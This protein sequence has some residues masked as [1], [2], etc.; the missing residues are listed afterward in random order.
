MAKKQ[1]ALNVTIGIAPI[2]VPAFLDAL[3]PVWKTCSEGPECILFNVF[4]DPANPGYFRFL[5]VGTEGREWFESVRP[6]L[7]LPLKTR[8]NDDELT[9]TL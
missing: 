1:L 2:D 8:R 9:G 3:R 6:I 5:K 7:S 4:L